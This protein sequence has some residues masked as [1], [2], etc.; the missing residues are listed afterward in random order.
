V[1]TMVQPPTS[2]GPG[3]L[4]RYQQAKSYWEK[5]SQSKSQELKEELPSQRTELLEQIR[6][7]LGNTPCICVTGAVAFRG[8]DAELEVLVG[9][10]AEKLAESLQDRVWFVTCGMPGVQKVFAARCGDGSRLWNLVS[11]GHTSQVGRGSEVHAG[12]MEDRRAIFGLLGDLYIIVEGG[13]GLAQQAK[14]IAS[15]GAQII[16]VMRSRGF[17]IEAFTRPDFMSEDQWALLKSGDASTTETVDA[18]VASASKFVAQRGP[19]ETATE[20]ET[21][22]GYAQT[23]EVSYPPQPVGS[24]HT[25]MEFQLE[26]SLS[27]STPPPFPLQESPLSTHG[28][29]A[30]KPR[31]LVTVPE[32]SV[33]SPKEPV[34]V[35][36]PLDHSLQEQTDTTRSTQLEDC[37]GE[38]LQHLATL[39]NSA[40]ECFLQQQ[41]RQQPEQCVSAS[42][43]PESPGVPPIDPRR[44]EF[45]ERIA[46]VASQAETL[47]K[48]PRRS[49]EQDS[50]PQ[51]PSCSGSPTTQAPVCNW[52][53]SCDA[54]LRAEFI[55][56]VAALAVQVDLLQN[57]SLRTTVA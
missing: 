16:P 41:Q 3:R 51:N 20:V 7:K 38:L 32:P 27:F 31:S 10:I 43:P 37:G 54:A 26:P 18:V 13:T 44:A 11:D 28:V 46:M 1:C 40:G 39:E 6:C 42:E 50:P 19:A 15:R 29:C 55:E 25:V 17:P 30:W 48:D 8:G 57:D 23:T 47:L 33:Q 4:E 5:A 21:G 12:S 34:T 52:P 22:S 24:S 36:E 56:R 45:L 9:H 53:Q 49:E 35:P 2:E 14:A